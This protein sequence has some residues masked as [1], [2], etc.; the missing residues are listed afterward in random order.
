MNTV[1]PIRNHTV[2]FTDMFQAATQAK[3]TSPS[4]ANVGLS[5]KGF[6][7]S[8]SEKFDWGGASSSQPVNQSH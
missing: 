5:K 6:T 3:Q 7:V 1:P 2:S 8:Q 4:N